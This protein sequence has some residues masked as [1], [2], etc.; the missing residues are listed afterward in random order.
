MFSVPFIISYFT[1]NTF[2]APVFQ[3]IGLVL[4]FSYY[5][6][7]FL[8]CSRKIDLGYNT[9][10]KISLVIIPLFLLAKTVIMPNAFIKP[11][12]FEPNFIRTIVEMGLAFLF[13]FMVIYLVLL[14]IR[15][16]SGNEKQSFKTYILHFFYF[17]LI[18]IGIL[19]LFRDLKIAYLK[20]KIQKS[21]N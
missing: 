20:N 11:D 5:L 9:A 13:Y 1:E 7:S 4:Y 2:F 14:Q 8:V 21:S 18:P 19:F 10:F 17:F 15:F 6:F 3:T 16:K 12:A